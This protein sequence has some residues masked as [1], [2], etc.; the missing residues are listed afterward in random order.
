MISDKDIRSI[1][2]AF[3]DIDKYVSDEYTE[4][5][6]EFFKE[7]KKHIEEMEQ[8]EQE[9]YTTGMIPQEYLFLKNGNNDIIKLD[10]KYFCEI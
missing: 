4:Q 5:L 8:L 2:E 9:I 10:K 6:K 3:G 7:D 1:K